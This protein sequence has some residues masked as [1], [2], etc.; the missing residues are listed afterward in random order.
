MALEDFSFEDFKSLT[1]WPKKDNTNPLSFLVYAV[2]YFLVILG[3]CWMGVGF[4]ATTHL[5]ENGTVV[6][7]CSTDQPGCSDTPTGNYIKDSISFDAWADGIIV[8]IVALSTYS[9]H[10]S[11]KKRK[12][13]PE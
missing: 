10:V 2:V 8:G 6:Q 11:N 3:F 7:F 13:K 5:A 1:V 4:N 9:I 12:D